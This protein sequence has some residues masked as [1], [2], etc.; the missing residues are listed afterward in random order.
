MRC[1][2]LTAFVMRRVRGGQE[3]EVTSRGEG[4]AHLKNS[5][6][7]LEPERPR[8][9]REQHPNVKCLGDTGQQSGQH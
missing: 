6:A 7:L 8:T 5:P 3:V 2:P 9:A 1:V 4:T